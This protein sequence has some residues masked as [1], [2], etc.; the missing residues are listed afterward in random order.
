[1]TIG[2]ALLQNTEQL[3]RSTTPALDAEVLLAA[4]LKV[5]RGFLFSH[6]EKKLSQPQQ[7]RF[8]RFISRRA[9]LEPVAY[10][11]GHKEFFGLDFLVNKNVL[12]PRPETELLVETVINLMKKTPTAKILDIGTGSGVMAITLKHLLPKTKMYAS[13]INRK[14]LFLAKK[15]AQQQKTSITFKHGSLLSPFPQLKFNCII[16]NPP[17][18]TAADMQNPQ[19]AFEPKQA[20]YGGLDG[21][22]VYQKLIPQAVAQLLPNGYLVLE[23]GS[24]QYSALRRFTR[25][26]FP[27]TT[28]SCLKDYTHRNRVLVIQP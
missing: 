15:N 24:T 10:I 7:D 17:Y 27:L 23:I 1:M 25:N 4:I 3:R 19:L 20:L 18:L 13:D 28:I 11:L 21:L 5:E 14:A 6:P 22:G 26:L 8:S 12:V 9:K 2:Q 16:S